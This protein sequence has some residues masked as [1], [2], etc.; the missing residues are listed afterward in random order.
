MN[1]KADEKRIPRMGIAPVQRNRRFNDLLVARAQ[2]FVK[3]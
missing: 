1:V 2:L 3:G